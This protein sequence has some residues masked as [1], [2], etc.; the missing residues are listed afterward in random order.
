MS[1]ENYQDWTIKYTDQ[2][3]GR[4]EFSAAELLEVYEPF[5]EAC[6]AIRAMKVGDTIAVYI[7]YRTALRPAG[8]PL[9][10]RL[11]RVK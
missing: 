10:T 9:M 8:E 11:T 7:G 6:T 1:V 4:P 5:D 3:Y 2:K